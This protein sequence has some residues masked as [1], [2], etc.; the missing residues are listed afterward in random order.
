V[1]LAGGSG[2]RLWPLARADHPKQ[3]LP[4]LGGRSLFRLTCDRVTPLVGQGRILVVAGA[5]HLAWI[6]RQAPEIPS[7]NILLEGTGR[8][9]AASVA[10][11][12][13]WVRERASDAI[14]MVLPADHRVAPNAAF[15]AALR[16][17]VA[18][19]H[20][21]NGLLTFGVAPRN[22]DAGFGYI[23]PG[24]APAVPGVFP[25]VAFVEKPGLARARRMVSSGA[26]FWNSGIFI[27]RA[28]TILEEL[29]RHRPGV[30]RPLVAWVA[31]RSGGPWR[32]PASVMRRL[33]AV[34]IDR[35]VLEHSDRVLMMRATFR[36]SDLGTW[37]A[38]W[39]ALPKDRSGNAAAGRVVAFDAG[40][41]LGVN[42][43][44][45]TVFLGVNDLV[46]V[47]SDH[48][49]LVLPRGSD[50][51]VRTLVERLGRMGLAGHL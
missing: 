20:R 36:W 37:S 38:L 6:R 22:A 50:Q 48:L 49:V 30:L 33:P 39:E 32:V 2:T 45:L 41:C 19:V 24:S 21:A 7:A 1:I 31:R 3:F 34:S 51:Q 43:T 12:A 25:V 8:N 35:A 29:L 18:A 47:R 46:V 16:R 44:G 15:V 11:A 17:A 28:A 23:R 4:L 13:L 10:L 27:F 9:T 5:R 14:M 40:R 42:P 26:H